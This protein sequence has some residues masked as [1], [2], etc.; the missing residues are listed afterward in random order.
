MKNIVKIVV[1][2]VAMCV[3]CKKEEKIP[4]SDKPIIPFTQIGNKTALPNGLPQPVQGAQGAT[5]SGQN[6]T[7]M[8]VAPGMNPSHGQPGHRCE[9]AVGAPLNSPQ[10]VN[11]M[12]APRPVVVQPK[13]ISV[14]AVPDG[15]APF[16]TPTGPLA[17][18]PE[19]INPPHGQDGHVCSVAVGAPLPK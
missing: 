17:P 3:S 9:I 13:V 5:T 1:L 10:S 11:T 14:P 6:T 15:S 18:T 19:G 2:S 7:P 8:Q 16:A 4:V 12:T